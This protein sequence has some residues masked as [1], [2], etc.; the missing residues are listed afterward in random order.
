M[1][2]QRETEACS[3]VGSRGQFP[4]RATPILVFEEKTNLSDLMPGCLLGPSSPTLP[5]W[6]AVETHI[7]RHRLSHCGTVTV[8]PLNNG[9][10]PQGSQ[11]HRDILYGHPPWRHSSPPSLLF[12]VQTPLCSLIGFL[13]RRAQR[14]RPARLLPARLLLVHG[15]IPQASFPRAGRFWPEILGGKP[16]FCKFQNTARFSSLWGPAERQD[17]DGV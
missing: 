8:A 15:A 1:C 17:S 2:E 7:W 6:A 16:A 5:S 3:H 12:S 11:P 4:A 10:T 14:N 9:L 13:S